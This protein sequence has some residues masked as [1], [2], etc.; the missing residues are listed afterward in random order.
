MDLATL[1][2]VIAG[3]CSLLLG[4]ALRKALIFYPPL[5]KLEDRLIE[6]Y[7][8]AFYTFK[9][10][11]ELLELILDTGETI[12]LKGKEAL[13]C[14]RIIREYGHLFGISGVVYS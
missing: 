5:L 11:E 7:E 12:T 9:R 6:L 3:A 14:F 10:K 1:L 2:V 13:K 4:L 8:V